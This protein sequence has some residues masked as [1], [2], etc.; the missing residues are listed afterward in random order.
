MLILIDDLTQ[1]R[2]HAFHLIKEASHCDKNQGRREVESQ[3][4]G[5]KIMV[6]QVHVKYRQDFD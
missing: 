3:R 6:S 1:I 2:F 5:F 4:F